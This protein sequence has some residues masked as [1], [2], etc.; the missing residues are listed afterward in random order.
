MK[1]LEKSNGNIKL[2]KE[3]EY[4]EQ[5]EKTICDLSDIKKYRA[6]TANE[7]N[8]L[9]DALQNIERAR[10]MSIVP[11][12]SIQVDVFTTDSLTGGFSKTHFYT[13]AE[14]PEHLSKEATAQ[15]AIDNINVDFSKRT[16]SDKKQEAML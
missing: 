5:L 7:E 3:F 8:N 13:K 1:R 9:S 10:E 6:L 12:D 11:E 2:A 16:E 14:A 4:L 15:Y